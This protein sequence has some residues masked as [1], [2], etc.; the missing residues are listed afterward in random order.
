MLRAGDLTELQSRSVVSDGLRYIGLRCAF[1]FPLFFFTLLTL[2]HTPPITPMS[3]ITRFLGGECV[4]GLEEV[5]GIPFN[6]IAAIP[7]T[8]T[9]AGALWRRAPGALIRDSL[10]DFVVAGWSSVQARLTP[11]PGATGRA[12][13]VVVGWG[14]SLN[15]PSSLLDVRRLRGFQNI[16]F[17]GLQDPTHEGHIIPCPLDKG[18]FASRVKPAPTTFGHPVLYAWV[19]TA[20]GPSPVPADIMNVM[21]TG[22]IDGGRTPP[23]F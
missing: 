4:V 12:C 11:G 5:V 22:V 8:L 17:G 10:G 1:S 13:S 9:P 16:V 3:S 18:L 14:S 23:F 21:F 7:H 2:T 20:T 15:P 19:V 6:D